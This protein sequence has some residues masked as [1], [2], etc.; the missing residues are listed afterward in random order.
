MKKTGIICQAKAAEILEISVS[1]L[2]TW[3]FKGLVTPIS[4]EFAMTKYDQKEIEELKTFLQNTSLQFLSIYF[5]ALKKGQ[6]N[7]PPKWAALV[8]ARKE[9]EQGSSSNREQAKPQATDITERLSDLNKKLTEEVFSF[10]EK[11]EKFC[12]EAREA[13]NLATTAVNEILRQ[14]FRIKKLEE[15]AERRMNTSN[16]SFLSRF[17]RGEK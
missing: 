17:L 13:K 11:L 5:P 2:K 3:Q 6:G 10:R 15:L 9:Q 14:D 4:N 7:I 8:K 1:T 12:E 16:N